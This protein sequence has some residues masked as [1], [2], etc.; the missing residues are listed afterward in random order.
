MCTPMALGIASLAATVLG[1]VQTAQAQSAAAAAQ[2]AQAKENAKAADAQ[3]RN[4]VLAAQ[5]E[6]DRRRAQTRAMLAA[7]RAAFA[8]NN[9]DMSMGTPMDLLGDTAAIGEQDALTIRANAARQ[10]WGYKVDANNYLNEGKVAKAA[11][12]N[13]TMGTYLT[14]AGTAFGQAA[15]LMKNKKSL[16]TT[17]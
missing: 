2:E 7:Q 5:V 9:V 15:N 14:T 13:A 17:G 1:G 11:G 3:A 8:A 10:A 16:T 12:Q 4:T 6:E